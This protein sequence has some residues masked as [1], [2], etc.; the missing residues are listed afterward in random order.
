M[1][2]PDALK[3]VQ[4]RRGY[5]SDEAIAD[6]AGFL[7]MTVEEVDSLAKFYNLIYRRPVGR[8]VIL[9]CDSV[10]CVVTGYDGLREHVRKTLG[11]DLGGTTAD[12]R[13]TLLPA[14]CLGHC[15]IAPAMIVDEDVHGNLTPE[16]LDEVLAKY[17]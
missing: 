9:I 16:R 14:A 12:G 3:I 6:V 8:H 15:E 1:V 10:S 11:V 7:G 13:F 17:P 2:V 5:V 4:R